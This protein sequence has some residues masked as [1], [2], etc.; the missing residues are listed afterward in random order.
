MNSMLMNLG[1]API[2]PVPVAKEPKPS[3]AESSRAKQRLMV[4]RNLERAEGDRLS[5]LHY[6]RT[7]KNVTIKALAWRFEW[8]HSKAENIMQTLKQRGQVGKIGVVWGPV[9]PD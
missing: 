3:R 4:A 6:I 8:T 2:P 5:A 7:E 1:L 9:C